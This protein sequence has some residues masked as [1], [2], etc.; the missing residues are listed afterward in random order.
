[1]ARPKM[2][3]MS[4]EARGQIAKVLTFYRRKGTQ[5]T[6]QYNKP[7]G[8]ASSAQQAIRDA[9]AA[10]AAL[11]NALTAGEKANWK[12]WAEEED[13][14]LSP[15][16][17]FTGWHVFGFYQTSQADFEAGTPTQVDLTTT[18]GDIQLELQ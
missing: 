3:L 16:P 1:M 2:P 9:V 13:P 17:F 4:G 11:W 8:V 12:T 6:R 18:P 5:Y 10:A 15:Y 7:T 14:N